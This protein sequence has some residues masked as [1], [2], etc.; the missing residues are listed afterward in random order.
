[1][2]SNKL[3][4]LIDR[5]ARVSDGEVR[6]SVTARLEEVSLALAVFDAAKPLEGFEADPAELQTVLTTRADE[7]Q[8][9]YDARADTYDVPEQ[10]RVRHILFRLAPDADETETEKVR[11]VAQST[12]DRIEAGEDMAELASELS[13]DPGSKSQGGDLGF[14]GRGQMVKEFEDAAFGQQV[15]KLGLTQ[16]SYGFHVIR[17]EDRREAE[18]RS[19]EQVQDELATELLATE[20]AQAHNVEVAESISEAIRGGAS[21]EDAARAAGLSLERTGRIRRRPDGY[22][23]GVGAAQELMAVAFAMKPGESSDRVFEVDDK[24][25]LVEVIEKFEPDEEAIAREFDKERQTLVSQ[26]RQ[27]YLSTWI[28]QRRT[29]LAE[30][31]QLIVNMD[32]LGRS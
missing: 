32:L 2:L 23:P 22:I 28:N 11:A 26:K 25:A 20:A 14:I 17:V 29:E 15:G 4:G 30:N 31:G 7:L 6:S 3:V 19:F 9:L 18:H 27:N 1:M 24:L 10:V 5:L 16:S 13:D 8:A 21:L 12:F